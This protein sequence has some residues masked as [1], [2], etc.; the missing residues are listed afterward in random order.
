MTS[1]YL[2]VLTDQIIKYKDLQALPEYSMSIPTGVTVGK[3]WRHALDGASRH[4]LDTTE[5]AIR[6]YVDDPDNEKSALI[7]SYRAVDGRGVP[8][9]GDLRSE[10]PRFAAANVDPGFASEPRPLAPDEKKPSNVT[11]LPVGKYNAVRTLRQLLAEAERGEIESVMVVTVSKPNGIG[12]QY[13]WSEMTRYNVLWMA[14][15]IYRTVVKRYFG[16]WDNE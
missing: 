15:Y 7:I 1:T 3:R 14:T 6:M 9:C 16:E 2:K 5:W 8:Y 11:E 12:L 13:A 10:E 4:E